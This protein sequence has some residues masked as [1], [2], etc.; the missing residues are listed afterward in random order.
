MAG[1]ILAAN[2]FV[3][4]A[5]TDALSTVRPRLDRP[6]PRVEI[7]LALTG[8]ARSGIDISDG[9][10]ADLG[11]VCTGSRLGAAIEV[12][13]HARAG[14]GRRSDAVYFLRRELDT[15]RNSSLHMRIQKNINLASLE[16]Q[17]APALDLSEHLGAK[18]PTAEWGLMLAE[19]RDELRRSWWLAIF[20]GGAIFL[21]DGY[22]NLAILPNHEQQAPNGLY[23]FGFEVENGE[24]IVDR[25]SKVN[26]NK[27]PKPRPNGRPYAETRGSDPDGNYFQLMSPM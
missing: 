7:G 8:V 13:A 10:L 12:Q 9:L 3:D 17:P 2:V 22:F 23:H 6:T 5:R 27:L 16:G 15:Y 24:K 14:Q 4:P 25:L 11:H 21:T 26:P 1:P 19:S 20:P 18:P